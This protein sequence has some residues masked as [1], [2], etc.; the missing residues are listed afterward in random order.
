MLCRMK[1]RDK[2]RAAR[3]EVGEVRLLPRIGNCGMN[4]SIYHQYSACPLARAMEQSYEDKLI[5]SVWNCTVKALLS[6]F[7]P[8]EL[9][10][11]CNLM[12]GKINFGFADFFSLKMGN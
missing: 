1:G 6:H 7:N 9:I 2:T 8:L 3:K 10:K 12:N 4:L 11:A 5:E